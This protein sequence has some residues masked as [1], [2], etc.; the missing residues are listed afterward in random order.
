M[1]TKRALTIGMLMAASIAFAYGQINYSTKGNADYYVYNDS[2]DTLFLTPIH[3][4][5]FAPSKSIRIF[6]TLQ[7]DGLGSK[8]IIFERHSAGE[9]RD[10]KQASQTMETT[11]VLKYEIWDIDTKTLLFQAVSGYEFRFDNWNLLTRHINKDND[12]WSRGYCSCTYDFSIDSTGRIKIS[13]LMTISTNNHCDA[14]KKEGF[15]T[16]INGKYTHE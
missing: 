12:G 11:K 4:G 14:D 10:I 3:V 7:I 5:A 15:Y 16:F 8:E 1:T 9:T 13:N 2:K 6:D